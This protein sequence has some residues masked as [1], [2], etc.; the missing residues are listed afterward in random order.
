MI[1]SRPLGWLKKTKRDQWMSH[2]LCWRDCSGEVTDWKG[3]NVIRRRNK[4]IDGEVSA[5]VIKV[6]S[7]LYPFEIPDKTISMLGSC[8]IKH[9]CSI[10]SF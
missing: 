3:K 10:L 7:A 6:R 8:I 2:V 5:L 4:N 9:N 1:L